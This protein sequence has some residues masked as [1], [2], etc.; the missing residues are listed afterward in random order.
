[1]NTKKPQKK[2][3]NNKKNE[4]RNKQNIESQDEK[5]KN[6]SN[7]MKTTSKN[8]E[9]KPINTSTKDKIYQGI[10]SKIEN[11]E[12]LLDQ[13]KSY[14]TIYDYCYEQWEDKDNFDLSIYQKN[15]ISG[16][17]AKI[18]DLFHG[19]LRTLTKEQ[20]EQ[21]FYCYGFYPCMSVCYSLK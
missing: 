5:D 10:L 9:K 15:H 19:A 8:N 4:K 14:K 12:E 3:P 17:K 2:K 21:L 6:I 18:A 7:K 16:D 20:R 11:K 13:E 1:M